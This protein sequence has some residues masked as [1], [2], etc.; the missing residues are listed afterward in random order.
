[1][2]VLVEVSAMACVF[3]SLLPTSLVPWLELI[4][5]LSVLLSKMR[6]GRE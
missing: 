1:M 2:Q 3:C 5:T 4:T 6:K